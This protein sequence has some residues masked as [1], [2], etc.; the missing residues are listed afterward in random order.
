MKDK[1]F[2]LRPSV[3]FV[4]IHVKNESFQR[5]DFFLSNTRRIVPVVFSQPIFTNIISELDGTK[6]VDSIIEYFG[7]N[8][9]K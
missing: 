9:E 5:F 2:R 6:S 3:S 8:H 7:N 1:Y 4:P